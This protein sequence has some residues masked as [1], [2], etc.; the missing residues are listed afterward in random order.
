V[1]AERR[2]VAG[3]PRLP[4]EG[5]LDLT[6]RCNNDC[7]H[8][9]LRL[10]ADSSRGADELSADEIR[11]I[12]D[13]G[14]AL[15]CRKW[16][17]SGGEPM[18]RPDFA[19]IFAYLTARSDGYLLNTNGTLITP[20]IARLLVRKGSKMVALYGATAKVHDHITRTPGA[21]EAVMRGFAYLKEAGASFIV[22]VVP[23]RDNWH[24]HEAMV[25]LA[26]TLS[27]S[28]RVGASWLCLSAGGSHERN[29]EIA[30]QRLAPE[31]VV[32]SDPPDMWTGGAPEGCGAGGA[33]DR[34]FAACILK[35]NEFHVDPYGGLSFCPQVKDPALRFDLRGGDLREAWESFLPALAE[36]TRGGHE[37]RTGCAR[38]D[39]RE[40]CRWCG[41]YAFLEHRRASASIDYLC[42]VAR[43]SRAYRESWN[44]HHR[45][46]YEVAGVTVQVDSD[47][48][49]G[50]GTFSPQL[51]AF[52]VSGPGRD[53]ISIHH[54]FGLPNLDGRDLGTP[55][56]RKAPWAVFRK[57][58]AW[59]YQ[60]IDPDPDDHRILGLAEFNGD[61]SRGQI[62]N[63]DEQ[64][65]RE[66][67]LN[68][69]TMAPTDQIV[70]ARV[71]ADRQACFLHSAGVV[72]DG[73]GL[74]FAGHSGAGKSTMVKLLRGR[75][76]ILCDDR[77]VVRRWPDGFRVHGTWCHGEI[78]EVSP[79][80]APLAAIFL[81]KKS[82]E[83]RLEKIDDLRH[84]L[85]ALLGCLV[86]PMVDKHW[87]E[88]ALDLVQRLA[89]EIPCY[90]L[91]FDQSGAIVPQLLE[92]ARRS[93]RGGREEEAAQAAP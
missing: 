85:V 49:I 4:L 39:L 57:G 5:K 20:E 68:A 63:V 51:A 48:P 72:M 46:Y 13:E 2:V 89:R 6:Y 14:R 71:L 58:G 19:E 90:E 35:R 1:S 28:Y 9:W 22:Q 86:K 36:R 59:I 73:V 44:Q 79:A 52:T 56:Y 54:H 82:D 25:H 33:D 42:Q 29:A 23:M 64:Y 21:Y 7:R 27:P 37:Y 74:V 62:W 83:N 80:S 77:N 32:A 88:K 12:A 50:N 17:I 47:L 45:R 11:R 24:E 16:G 76:E 34:L 91:S 18:L 61:H 66:G 60:G 67:G 55:V 69:L 78:R 38:C 93:G 10:P 84:V 65:Y 87:W 15:G 81:L 70:L 26:Q 53:T 30:R 75:A 8:C 40:D 43:E 41:A 3:W 92:L 31:Q